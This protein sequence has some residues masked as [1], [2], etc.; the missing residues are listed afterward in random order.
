[1]PSK[2][3]HE[4]AAFLASN[5][6]D[7]EL[8]DD[9]VVASVE[10]VEAVA[11]GLEQLRG[12]HPVRAEHRVRELAGLLQSCESDDE[13]VRNAFRSL[14]LPQ[15][16]EVDARFALSEDVQS[17]RMFL[18]KQIAYFG[19]ESAVN[20]IIEA[21]RAGYNAEGYM[22]SV[23]LRPFSPE[24]LLHRELFVG[25]GESPPVGFIGVSLLD[26]AN[27]A[28]IAGGDFPHP[29][30][31]PEGVK[32]LRAWLRDLDPGSFSYARS[33]TA[34]L[35]FIPEPFRTELL[36]LAMDH[37]DTGVSMEAGW[38]CGKVG[39]ERGIR[40]LAD[41]ATRVNTAKTAL[42][43][44][45]ELGREDAI[46]PAA[47]VPDFQAT[48]EMAEWLAHPNE[49]GEPPESLELYDTRE[50]FWPP[51][52]DRRLVWLFKYRYPETADRVE[53]DVG[54][55]MVGS[56]TFALFGEVTAELS[57]LDAYAL[58]CCWELET[59]QDERAPG[60]RSVS[61]GREILGRDN[62]LTTF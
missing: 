33:A 11:W 38:A 59:N 50:L 35:P 19:V 60:E 22:W 56:V 16:L 26:A 9:C 49:F 6:D 61:A 8:P 52:N 34:A 18:L 14:V 42:R 48:A 53:E 4:I 7:P 51:T 20:R 15:L 29:F 27:A 21:A 5:V 2:A 55:G 31:G 1:M 32:R 37:P 40:R 24:H 13:A 12:L 28:L 43:Y 10:D 39:S 54:L 36:E 57:P 3:R 17:C 46:P 44:L 58:H 45:E 23:I 30:G 25:L 41:Y 62:D 47:R